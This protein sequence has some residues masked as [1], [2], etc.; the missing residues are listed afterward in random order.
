MFDG[1]SRGSPYS[2]STDTQWAF[3]R[4]G[5]RCTWDRAEV[6]GVT[7][8]NLMR[9][10]AAA[11]RDRGQVNPAVGGVFAHKDELFQQDPAAAG[12]LL[13]ALAGC[14]KGSMDILLGPHFCDG[15]V[16]V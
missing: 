3:Q 12:I 7:G 6:P 15:Q 16:G 2:L 9:N 5:V 1:K 10:E 11:E 13:P 8:L 14:F 4:T